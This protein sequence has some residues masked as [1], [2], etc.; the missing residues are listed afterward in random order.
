MLKR[1]NLEFGKSNYINHRK[2]KRFVTSSMFDVKLFWNN[3]Q[4]LVWNINNIHRRA[5]L[6]LEGTQ[7]KFRAREILKV[8]ST[9][10]YRT[11]SRI[12]LGTGAYR[13]R[14][15]FPFPASPHHSQ[16]GTNQPHD[17]ST[18]QYGII[19]ACMVYTVKVYIQNIHTVTS[20]PAACIGFSKALVVSLL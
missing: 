11:D 12:R 15:P 18:Y 4:P 2:L 7:E 5:P 3:N 10:S 19:F 9:E 1:P 17:Q 16:E 14:V 8:L 6:L 13:R 20:C